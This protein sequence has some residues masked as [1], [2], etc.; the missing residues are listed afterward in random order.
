[1]K[2]KHKMIVSGNVIELYTYEKEVRTGKDKDFEKENNGRRGNGLEW[3]EEDRK[4]NRKESLQKAKKRLRREINANVG[5]WGAKTKFITLTYADNLTDVKE[6]NLNFKNFI[7]RLNYKMDLKLKYSC[8]VEFQKRGAVHYHL[9]AYNLP[10]LE[11]SK[12][13]EIWGHGF[14]KINEIDHVDN[15]GA[16]VTKYMTKEN[17]DERLKGLKCHFSSRGLKKPTEQILDIEKFEN[18]ASALESH[19]VYSAEFDS[20]WLGKINYKQIN[21][22]RL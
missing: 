21:L 10:Y 22:K 12:L 2:Y 7:K 4:K 14:V 6:S 13:S 19:Q 17:D 11:N 1:M 20:E 5:Q 9:L 16:Y 15:V 18:V 8:V 3:I